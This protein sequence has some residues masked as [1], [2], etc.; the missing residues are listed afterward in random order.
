VTTLPVIVPAGGTIDG[1][2]QQAAGTQLRCL[3]PIGSDSVL[4]RVVSALKDSGLADP[5]IAAVPDAVP[6]AVNGVDLWAV[7]ADLGTQS[8]RNGL[9]LAANAERVLICTSD[10]PFITAQAVA[11]FVDRAAADADVSIGLVTEIDYNGAFPGSPTSIFLP[12]RETGPITIGCLFLLKLDALKRI[13]PWLDRLFSARKSLFQSARLLGPQIVLQLLT[14]RLS[15]RS[16]RERAR[17]LVGIDIDVLVGVSPVLAF[18][19][20]T[21]EDYEYAKAHI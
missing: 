2:F 21:P 12:I 10:L 5:V 6:L 20:D 1:R 4:Q 19:I 17:Q 8:I 9:K 15:I 18:D 14:K 3:A 16:L 13:D 11:D 7:S